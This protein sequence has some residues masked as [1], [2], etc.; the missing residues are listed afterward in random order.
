MHMRER[1]GVRGEAGAG[2]YSCETETI[3][4]HVVDIS[5]WLSPRFRRKKKKNQWICEQEGTEALT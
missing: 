2:V 5:E 1:G 3:S 4:S